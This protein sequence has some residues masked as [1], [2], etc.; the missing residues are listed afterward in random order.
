MPSSPKPGS[1]SLDR[2]PAFD[3]DDNLTA[4]VEAT[5]GSRNKFKYDGRTG[6]FV[7]NGVLP[8]GATFPFDF[9]FVPST[10][11]EDG[12]PIDVLI[13]MDDPAF[14]GAV[15][16]SR[17]VGAI[18]AEQTEDEAETV[19]NDRLIAIAD[20]S[21]LYRGVDT[22]EALPPN[23]VDEIEHFWISYN[24]IKGKRFK[25]IG[26]VGPRGAVELVRESLTSKRR[27]RR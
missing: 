5:R 11:G 24:A 14:V 2:L 12:D 20:K 16:P 22:I 10:K 8:A 9:G 6:V 3:D 21:H 25:P 1:T 26:R 15:V 7:L 4:V 18:Q 13:L 23:L 27:R 17:L 19:R